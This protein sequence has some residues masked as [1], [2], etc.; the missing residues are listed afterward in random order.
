[1]KRRIKIREDT[2]FSQSAIATEERIR[3]NFTV[4]VTRETWN[5]SINKRVVEDVL[6]VPELEGDLLSVKRLTGNG[7]TNTSD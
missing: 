1:M 6:Y 7:L 2:S 3:R 4:F 5:G